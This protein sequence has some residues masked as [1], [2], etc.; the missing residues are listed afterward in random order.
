M[1]RVPARGSDL[2]A[3]V[4]RPIVVMKSGRGA[5][6]KMAS[7][8]CLGPLCG[9]NTDPPSQRDAVLAGCLA[10]VLAWGIAA[11]GIFGAGAETS[12]GFSGEQGTMVPRVIGRGGAALHQNREAAKKPPNHTTGQLLAPMGQ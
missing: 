8:D 1:C 10:S 11:F 6:A 9:K 5:A 4:V 3:V 12:T 7:P 2:L